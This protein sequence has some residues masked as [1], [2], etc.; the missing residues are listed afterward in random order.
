MYNAALLL[1]R[2]INLLVY[3]PNFMSTEKDLKLIWA[4]VGVSALL[5]DAQISNTRYKF[6]VARL[7]DV[8]LGN[9]KRIKEVVGDRK[10]AN[11]KYKQISRRKWADRRK[12]QND[13][14]IEKREEGW[15][16]RAYLYRSL[17]E[18]RIDGNKASSTSLGNEGHIS[19]PNDH[20]RTT[21]LDCSSQA[22]ASQRHRHV[23]IGTHG[24]EDIS[25]Q[26]LILNSK[27]RFRTHQRQRYDD[28]V[29][30]LAEFDPHDMV[31]VVEDAL[32]D[33]CERTLLSAYGGTIMPDSDEVHDL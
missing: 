31:K 29:E 33:A 13:N 18:S 21:Q 28:F 11:E 17:E 12:P 25:E 16:S 32:N 10:F 30:T 4:G 2:L 7:V 15:N 26:D 14:E 8:Y 9:G 1:F 3:K 5:L 6:H 24:V 19:R 20:A 22:A 27:Y 23:D